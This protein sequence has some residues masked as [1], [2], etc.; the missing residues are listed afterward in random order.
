MNF[1]RRTTRNRFTL[2]EM[3]VAMAVLSVVVALLAAAGNQVF[4][5]WRRITAEQARFT[6]L[7][8][9]D[10]T[11]DAMFRNVVPFSWRNVR[12]GAGGKVMPAFVG[13]TD[14]V[15]FVYRHNLNNTDD[16]ALRFAGL[17][18]ENGELKAVY[19]ERPFI[20]WEGA[21]SPNRQESVLAR[22][23]A[24][25]SLQYANWDMTNSKIT[26]TDHWDATDDATPRRDVPL[27]LFLRVKWQDGREETWLRRTPGSGQY[28][29]LG[30]WIPRQEDTG[31]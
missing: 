8:T 26:W 28:A 1:R 6:E 10:R 13:E 19:Q 31:T 11:V 22:D 29:R 2:V 5:S 21:P 20:D 7:L 30:H 14:R 17:F 15:R 4:N 27:A 24:S 16:G 9:L 25:I 3:V 12:E 23:V 18:V